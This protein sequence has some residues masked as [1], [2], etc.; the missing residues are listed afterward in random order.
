[1]MADFAVLD[2]NIFEIDKSE[3]IK[4]KVLMTVMGGNITY[5]R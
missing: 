1:M 2:R 5:K 3:I 4:T